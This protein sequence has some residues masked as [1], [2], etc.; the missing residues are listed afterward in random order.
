VPNYNDPPSK[1]Y[2]DF[3]TQYVS[4]TGD[5]N[6]LQYVKHDKNLSTS[7]TTTWV[8]EWDR[9]G[10]DNMTSFVSSADNYPA[11]S[12][13]SEEIC[14]PEV[15]DGMIL[16]TR[17]VIIDS[18]QSLSNVLQERTTTPAVLFELWKMYRATAPEI[19]YEAS[20]LF[21]AFFDAL[22]MS[23]FYGDISQWHQDR[24]AYITM[25]QRLTSEMNESK[26]LVW[27]NNEVAELQSSLVHNLIAEM[28]SGK[29]FMITK[30]GYIGLAPDVTGEDDLCGIIF[31]CTSPCMLRGTSSE[32]H[33]IFVGSSFMLG[34]SYGN[35]SDTDIDRVT[36]NRCFGVEASKDWLEWD[37]EEQD[38]YLC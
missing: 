33:Y 25:F 19:P 4:T 7:S 9:K 2:R 18:V 5:V 12:S 36:F 16:K 37:I 11:L 3:A 10:D 38:I 35:F 6:I 14:R 27:D 13:R 22:A 20:Y 29:R 1:V 26:E 15:I 32:G 21:E 24:R 8:P 31:G 34:K 23:S 17:G 30:R 28:T